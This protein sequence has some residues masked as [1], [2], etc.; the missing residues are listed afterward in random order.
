MWQV[1]VALDGVCARIGKTG[2]SR[3]LGVFRPFRVFLCDVANRYYLGANR[4]IT[5]EVKKS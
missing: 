3:L 4:K 2:K 1:A 5:I